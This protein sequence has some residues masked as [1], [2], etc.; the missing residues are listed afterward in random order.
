MSEIIPTVVPSAFIDVT[1]AKDRYGAF[2]SS[3]HI[4]AADGVFAPNTTWLPV[5]GEKLPDSG[6]IMY[7]AHLMIEHPLSAGVSFARAGAKRVIGHIEAFEN[8]ECAREAFDMWQKAGAT[9]MGV[10]ILL[11]TPLEELAPYLSL[12]DFVH[13]MTIEKI[14]K[15][16]AQ[17]DERSIERV[18]AVHAR[19]PHITI[20]VDG[21]GNVK[22][23]DVLAH[24]GASRFCAGSA[25]AKA[26]DPAKE[27]SRLLNAASAIQ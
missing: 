21:G 10:A 14:G 17:F 12:C 5:N 13:M 6:R 8:A 7:E 25:L 19:Y 27:Y 23:I 2:A 24:A 4:D 22:T 15:Q 9:E 20:S 26:K 16:G 11:S 18:E 1:A 3:L